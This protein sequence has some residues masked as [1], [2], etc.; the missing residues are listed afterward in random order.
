MGRKIWP[1]AAALLLLPGDAQQVFGE[2][3]RKPIVTDGRLMCHACRAIMHQLH[4]KLRPARSHSDVL[5]QLEKICE[6]ASLRIY[7]YIPPKMLKGCQDFQATH[8]SD[9]LEEIVVKGGPGPAMSDA[10]CVGLTGVCEGIDWSAPTGVPG[11]EEYVPPAPSSES[12]A[13]KKRKKQKATKGKATTK[14][15]KTAD[16]KDEV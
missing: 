8:S 3:P 7:E 1:L 16:V 15:T 12:P 10:I 2:N 9:E 13:G 6:V 11:Y 5:E 4:Q 14:A